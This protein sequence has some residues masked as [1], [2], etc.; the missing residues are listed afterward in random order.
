MITAKYFWKCS[1]SLLISQFDKL[2]RNIC[3]PAYLA[4]IWP[5]SVSSDF[6]ME[7]IHSTSISKRIRTLWHYMETKWFQNDSIRRGRGMFTTKATLLFWFKC[8]EM[9]WFLWNGVSACVGFV[10]KLNWFILPQA[11]SNSSV[12]KWFSDICFIIDR[13]T[14]V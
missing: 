1:V 8:Q 2:S 12:W 9:C 3:H 4:D 7:W 13:H 10:C 5:L 6:W 14:S 11:K